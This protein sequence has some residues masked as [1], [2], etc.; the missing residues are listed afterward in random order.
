MQ[1]NLG[2]QYHNSG[3]KSAINLNVYKIW[4]LGRHQS[5]LKTKLWELLKV[6]LRKCRLKIDFFQMLCTSHRLSLFLIQTY[7]YSRFATEK[8]KKNTLYKCKHS[9]AL[10]TVVRRHCCPS[11]ESS[12]FIP[13]HQVIMHYSTW[14]Q[15]KKLHFQCVFQPY[16]EWL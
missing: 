8:Y 7:R 5:S 10:L 4:G 16:S 6:L 11:S 13:I 14:N 2:L 12:H 15:L 1:A 9:S 3:K